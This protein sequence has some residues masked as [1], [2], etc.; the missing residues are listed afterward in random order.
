MSNY[1]IKSDLENVS[2]VVT[3]LLKRYDLVNLKSEIDRL[4][5]EKLKNVPSGLSS[6]K[7]KIDKLNVH[8]LVFFF[9]WFKYAK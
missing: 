7:D 2:G 8:N 9:S 5:I 4:D 6:F 3:S 1:E